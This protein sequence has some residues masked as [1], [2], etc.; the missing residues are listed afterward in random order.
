MNPR[1]ALYIIL[2]IPGTDIDT[3]LK[4]VRKDMSLILP[5]NH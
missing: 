2:A 5:Q 1:R 4:I 3:K